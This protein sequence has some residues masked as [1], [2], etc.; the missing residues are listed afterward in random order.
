MN[1]GSKFAKVLYYSKS[2]IFLCSDSKFT[3]MFF[4]IV[5]SIIAVTESEIL[6]CFHL[7]DIINRSP[8]LKNVVSSVT[9]NFR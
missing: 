4:Y 6:Y 7:L 8:L 9:G 1:L 3:Y 5:V 2:F